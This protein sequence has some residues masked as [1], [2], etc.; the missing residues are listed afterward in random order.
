V[1][2]VIFLVLIIALIGGGVAI[3]FYQKKSETSITNSFKIMELEP[4]VI[5]LADGHYIRIAIAIEY[6]GDEEELRNKLPVINDILI[7]TVG[8]M[9]SKELVSPEGKEVLKEN[10]LLKLNSVL[11]KTKV[12]NIFY[13]EFIIQ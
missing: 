5:N 6:S 8:A 12:R 13:R 11:T 10:L 9:S 4:V 2:K 7:T 1:K 3:Y